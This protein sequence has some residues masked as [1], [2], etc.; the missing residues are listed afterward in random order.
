MF[1]KLPFFIA[2]LAPLVHLPQAAA[3]DLPRTYGEAKRLANEHESRPGAKESQYQTL[4]PYFAEAY[5]PVFKRCFDSLEHPDASPFNFVVALDA[6]GEVL[7]LYRDRETNVQNCMASELVRDQFPPPIFSP[8]MLNIE[9]TFSDTVDQS[10]NAPPLP[11]VLEPDKYSYTFGLPLGWTYSFDEAPARARLVFFPVGGG[12]NE[13]IAIVY[14]NEIR[15]EGG[16]R[17]LED[18]MDDVITGFKAH[19]PRLKVS[20]TDPIQLNS[21]SKAEVRLFTGARDPVQAKEAI[22]FI[23]ERD[24]VVIVVLTVKNPGNWPSDNRIFH[25]IVGGYQHFTCETTDLAVPCN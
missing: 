14:V 23:E 9:M 6:R 5:S 2:L 22:A 18:A 17:S 16:I 25:E 21:G 24:K 19:S 11:I 3:Q 13:S 8:Y 1:R 7:H 15:K 12:F 10:A 20:T 4:L